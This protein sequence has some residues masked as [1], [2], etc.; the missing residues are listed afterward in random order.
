MRHILSKQLAVSITYKPGGVTHGQLKLTF[1]VPRY[2]KMVS[3]V[4]L[5]ETLQEG[6]L[7]ILSKISSTHI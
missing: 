6:L 3:S 1:N 4:W 2:G 5:A 7:Q